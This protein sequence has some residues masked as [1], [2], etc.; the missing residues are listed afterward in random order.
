[1]S[2][3]LGNKKINSQFLGNK[4]IIRTY[5][6]DELINEYKPLY[7]PPSDWK[8]DIRTDC[9][10][11][12]IALYAA[13]KSD[14][15]QY[16]NLG[17][18]V[19]CVGGYNVFIDGT[20]YGTTYASGA[21]CSITWSTSGITTGDDITTP[22]ALKAHKIW[23]E[24]ATE[25]AEITA[26]H[27]SRVAASGQKEQGILWEHFNITNAINISTLNAVGNYGS[28][29]YKNTLLIA[30][31]AKNNLLKVSGDLYCSFFLCEE[32]EYLPI[33]DGNN[34]KVDLG[35]FGFAGCNTIKKIDIRNLTFEEGS[36]AF[37]NCTSLEKLPKGI[38]YVSAHYMSNY[39]T[40]ANS[41][42][43]AILDVSSATGLK[44]IGCFNI[45]NLK[46]LR[47]SNQAAFDNWS[48]QIDI[49]NTGMDRNALVQLFNDLPYNVGYEVVGSP[50]IN[51]GVVSGFSASDY[52]NIPYS[53][54]DLRNIVFHCKFKTGSD[55]TTNQSILQFGN[56]GGI[57]PFL[58]WVSG[59]KLTIFYAGKYTSNNIYTIINDN[60][61]TNTDYEAEFG[62]VNSVRYFKFGTVGNM[63]NIPLTG[64]T[65]EDWN[66][67][68]SRILW[69]G[70]TGTALTTPFTG[71][72]DLNNT[73]IKMNDVYWFRGQAA[74][75]KTINVVGCTGTSS[76]TADDRAIVT[77]KGWSITYQ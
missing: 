49:R 11:N 3:I 16:D 56:T 32:L 46:G 4:P 72:I 63:V 23:I 17:F 51:N 6:G 35:Y 44:A 27:C 67:T 2:E 58:L 1:M 22:S 50:T 69:I 8:T 62:T 34:T 30:C 24:P 47:V 9:P 64:G 76:L 29:D 52:L 75:T 60:L 40:N 73:Y 77:D 13:H 65:D 70:N 59:N 33:I 18:T 28:Q 68:L 36:Y 54:L 12:S 21:T 20:Q 57:L 45:A 10:E 38:N 42:K 39:L 71:S 25:G 19:T 7:T 48:P 41:L 31:T 74:M 43:N 26:F 15:S 14:F 55:I 37:F 61:S 5:K 53:R 66:A